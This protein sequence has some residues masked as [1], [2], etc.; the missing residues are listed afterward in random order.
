MQRSVW[1]NAIPGQKTMHFE[2]F[3]KVRPCG[4]DL[5]IKDAQRLC[6]ALGLERVEKA[7]HVQPAFALIKG[8]VQLGAIGPF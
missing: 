3:E 4:A 7:V 8:R 1:I 5:R 2:R 6:A